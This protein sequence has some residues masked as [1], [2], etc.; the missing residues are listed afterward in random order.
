MGKKIINCGSRKGETIAKLKELFGDHKMYCF[1]PNPVFNKEY[2][3]PPINKAVWIEN[4][5]KKF[6]L[7]NNSQ[8]NS[9]YKRCNTQQTID[10]ECID[11]SEWIKQFK[12]DYLIV[13]MDIEGAEF[14]VLK[15]MIKD[16]TIDYVNELL[17]EFHGSKIEECKH[18]DKEEIK[19]QIKKRGVKI[20]EW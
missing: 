15:K 4:T 5:T 3:T 20:K 13:K 12:E 6:R 16:N 18:Y 19:E 14:E 2:K 8:S 11:F 1:E 7:C 10:V 17:V 9:L